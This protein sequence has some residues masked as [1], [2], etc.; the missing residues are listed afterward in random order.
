MH[1]EQIWLYPAAITVVSPQCTVFLTFQ[2]R[3]EVV[4]IVDDVFSWT[5]ELLPD[6]ERLWPLGKIQ[7]RIHLQLSFSY[8]SD[9]SLTSQIGNG[10]EFARSRLIET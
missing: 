9:A 8:A 5:H 7:K 4:I 3:Y 6:I 10:I 1:I 2:T